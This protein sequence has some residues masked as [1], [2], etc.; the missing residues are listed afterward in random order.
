MYSVVIADVRSRRYFQVSMKLVKRVHYAAPCVVVAASFL[1]NASAMASAVYYA[2]SD[3]LELV[4]DSDEYTYVAVRGDSLCKLFL[5]E[6]QSNRYPFGEGVGGKVE[7][8]PLADDDW[9]KQRDMVAR[10]RRWK[11]LSSAQRLAALKAKNSATAKNCLGLVDSVMER[12]NEKQ[13]ACARLGKSYRKTEQG[14]LC[15]SDFEYAQLEQQKKKV[16]YAGT[17][18]SP[19]SASADGC[20]SGTSRRRTVGLFG[21]F[22]RNLGCMTDYEANSYNQQN[23]QNTLNNINRNRP[24]YCTTNMVGNQAFTSCY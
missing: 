6:D 19:F 5:F 20:P 18:V 21:L 10:L 22:S 14:R 9:N 8:W 17:L 3:E 7:S 16:D 12:E 15:L 13:I 2:D 1:L 24:R 4:N 11:E 23:L